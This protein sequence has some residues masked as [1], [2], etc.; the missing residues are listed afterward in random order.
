MVAPADIARRSILVGVATMPIAFGLFVLV[1][2]FR[3]AGGDGLRAVAAVLAA[4]LGLGVLAL[5]VTILVA[6]GLLERFRASEEAIRAGTDALAA[7][8]DADE[9]APR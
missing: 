5:G 4:L 8:E 1:L 3:G 2:A 9:D 7:A 6:P